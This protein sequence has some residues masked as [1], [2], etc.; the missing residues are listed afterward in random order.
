MFPS[1]AKRGAEQAGASSFSLHSF[2]SPNAPLGDG[3]GAARRPY[4]SKANFYSR[5]ARHGG[6]VD[7]RS[8]VVNHPHVHP[9]RLQGNGRE[10]GAG[11]GEFRVLRVKGRR[12]LRTRAGIKQVHFAGHQMLQIVIVSIEVGLDFVFLQQR[13]NV[14][15]Q[16]RRVAVSATG[17]NR[18]MADH[19]LPLCL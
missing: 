5:N 13:Q 1:A 2:P 9:V 15:D 3:D 18:M 16:F 12:V 4:Q 6:R 14:F 11:L 10:A 17:I 19:D 8:A 7:Q